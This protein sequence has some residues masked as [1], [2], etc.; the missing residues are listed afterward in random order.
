M[1]FL[2]DDMKFRYLQLLR[3]GIYLYMY[4]NYRQGNKYKV[5]FYQSVFERV[6]IVI[7]FIIIVNVCIKVFEEYEF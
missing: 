1:Y 3:L 2:G 5:D 6:I 4:I 7:Q